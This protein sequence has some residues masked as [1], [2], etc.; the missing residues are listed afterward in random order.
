MFRMILIVSIFLS[1][2]CFAKAKSHAKPTNECTNQLGWV[3]F[4][5]GSTDSIQK[6][7]YYEIEDGTFKVMQSLKDGVLLA[8]GPRIEAAGVFSTK[9]IFLKT[10]TKLADED[11]W[12]ASKVF[13]N[14]MKSYPSILGSKNVNSFE[15][16]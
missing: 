5:T 10:K 3:L 11:P 9:I 14:G 7:C 8:P 6:N 16:L 4:A 15:E 12:P 1:V 2:P 13:L